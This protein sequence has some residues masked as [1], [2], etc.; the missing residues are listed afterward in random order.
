M[1]QSQKEN[2]PFFRQI[3]PYYKSFLKD[4]FDAEFNLL[5]GTDLSVAGVIPGYSVHE[6]MAIWQ[7]A[8][9][10]PFE[11]L[12]S[13]TIIP[14]RFMGVDKSLGSIKEGKKASFVLLSENPLKDI[15]NSQK[16]EG[17]FLRG[18]FFSRQEID[19]IKLKIITANGEMQHN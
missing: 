5:I 11:I 9:I 15:K 16:I 17:V 7:E 12:R 3:Y 14:A 2:I 1:W 10:P 4:L 13:A 19:S 8:G 6:E 18:N